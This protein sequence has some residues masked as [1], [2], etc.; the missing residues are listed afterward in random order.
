MSESNDPA[1]D[2]AGILEGA[3]LRAV[4]AA[5]LDRNGK[6][7]AAIEMSLT[8]ARQI[9]MVPVDDGQARTKVLYLGPHFTNSLHTLGLTPRGEAEITKILEQ[10]KLDVA[11]ARVMDVKAEGAHV[12]AP[13]TAGAPSAPPA[14]GGITDIRNRRNGTGR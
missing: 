7:G 3:V 13:A 14:R 8:Y 5:G 1:F 4:Q 12:K 10:T 11:R 2:G 9:D 6:F